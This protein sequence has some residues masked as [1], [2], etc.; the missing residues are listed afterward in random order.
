MVDGI[1]MVAISQGND[2]HLV[3]SGSSVWA[4]IVG[5]SIV[6]NCLVPATILDV[7]VVAI[8]VQVAQAQECEVA[9][10]KNILLCPLGKITGMLDGKCAER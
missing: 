1:E 10:V 4:E 3:E 8:T 9:R 7:E 5:E 2:S 6:S